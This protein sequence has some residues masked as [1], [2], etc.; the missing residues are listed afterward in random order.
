MHVPT[1][2]QRSVTTAEAVDE[3]HMMAAAVQ[4]GEQD[5]TT[6]SELLTDIDE[7]LDSIED[8]DR[9]LFQEELQELRRIRANNE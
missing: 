1:A 4:S 8:E 2:H 9:S 3:L 6:N 7:L 5:E